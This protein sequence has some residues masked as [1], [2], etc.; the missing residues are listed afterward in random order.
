MGKGDANMGYFVKN[1][2]P[3]ERQIH[4]Q[5]HLDSGNDNFHILNFMKFNF[6]ICMVTLFL[7]TFA[8]VIAKRTLTQ[9]YEVIIH[10]HTHTA[11]IYT[12]LI[13]ELKKISVNLF[14]F[15]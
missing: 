14:V 12:I 2:I 5:D 6:A 9:G 4:F 1:G 15:F 3:P 13:C 8:L 11:Q 10:T 7:S